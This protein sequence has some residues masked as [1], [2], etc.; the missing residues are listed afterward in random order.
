M[1]TRTHLP[2]QS[3]GPCRCGGQYIHPTATIHKTAVIGPNVTIGAG[4]FIGAH[5]VIGMHAEHHQVDVTKPVAGRV[6][7]FPHAIIHELVTIQ[8][9]TTP[10]SCTRIGFRS[11]IQAHAHVG[12]DARVHDDVTVSC[13]AKVGGH[14]VVRSWTNLGLNAVLHQFADIGE[15]CMIGASAFVKG[16]LKPW[17]KY[18]GVPARDIGENT[19][20]LERKMEREREESE[21]GTIV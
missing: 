6:E 1:A 9:S 19:I 12:H 3:D 7:I 8:A 10:E 14:A 18:A 5:A 4:V 15:G 13:G 21:R 17:R 20:G 2:P 16:T 11:R